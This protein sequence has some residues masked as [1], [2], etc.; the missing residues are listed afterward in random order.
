[1]E[2]KCSSAQ[3]TDG[4]KIL[5]DAVVEW[6]REQVELTAPGI[7]FRQDYERSRDQQH[8]DYLRGADQRCILPSDPDQQR[9]EYRSVKNIF[10]KEGYAYIYDA[11]ECNTFR[12]GLPALWPSFRL[13]LVP[14]GQW[15][16][17]FSPAAP[18]ASLVV[19][20]RRQLAD[21]TQYMAVLRPASRHEND[22][23]DVDVCL[24]TQCDLAL[25]WHS[26]ESQC[27]EDSAVRTLAL[28]YA[29]TCVQIEVDQQVCGKLPCQPRYFA[30]RPGAILQRLL[31]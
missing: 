21:A 1:M 5:C 22:E 20:E 28:S 16:L 9:G 12:P 7:K 17:T 24:P 4:E 23:E 19:D 10:T 27:D 3:Y 8:F 18:I 6:L 26:G 31:K 15:W 13:I 25:W 2:Y 11:L 14:L 30:L 29:N